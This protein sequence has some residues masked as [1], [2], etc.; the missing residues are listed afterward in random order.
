MLQTQGRRG[1]NPPVNLKSSWKGEFE[2]KTIARF[3]PSLVL[4]VCMVAPALAQTEY[5][6]EVYGAGNVTKDKPFMVG[7]PQFSP[8]LEGVYETSPGGR[9]GLRMGVDFKKYWG[10]DIIYSY[11]AAASKIVNSTSDIRFPLS[12]RSHVF[13]VNGLWYPRGMDEKKRFFP[14]VTAGVGASFFV[15]TNR[16]INESKEGGLGE[17]YSE[18]L[19]AFNAGG[20]VRARWNR[21]M[22]FRIDARDFMSRSPR[23]G[24]PASS[25]DPS[26]LV[27][28]AGGTFHQFEVSIAFVYYF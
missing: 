18:N 13:A 15:L 25:Y 24:M 8:P 14:Y 9:A 12:V 20:G 17:L 21:H 26:A 23:F 27:F 1:F 16:S 19:L 11:G 4:F 2:M 10:E 22:G 28:P 6:F 3:C 7:L 5:R